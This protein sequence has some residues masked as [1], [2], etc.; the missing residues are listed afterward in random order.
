MEAPSPRVSKSSK[1]PVVFKLYIQHK[2]QTRKGKKTRNWKI[3]ENY[4]ALNPS[5]L[6]QCIRVQQVRVRER[7]AADYI[8]GQISVK[9]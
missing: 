3:V 9:C 4:C 2:L 8:L 5:A 7:G 1:W 6:R